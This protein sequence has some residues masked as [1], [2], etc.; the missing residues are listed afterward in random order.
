MRCILRSLIMA[1][2]TICCVMIAPNLVIAA[3]ANPT[4]IASIDF[5]KQQAIAVQVSLSNDHNELK[6][7]PDRLPLSLANVTSYY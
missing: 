6:F 3:P 4:K 2:F 5:T 1:I 7:I